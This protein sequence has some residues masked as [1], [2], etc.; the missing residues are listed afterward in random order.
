MPVV[1][2]LHCGDQAILQYLDRFGG[3]RLFWRVRRATFGFLHPGHIY[4]GGFVPGHWARPGDGDLSRT[5]P[6]GVFRS[7]GMET[8]SSNHRNPRRQGTGDQ[9]QHHRNQ[10]NPVAGG[11]RRRNTENC[12]LHGS[13]RQT[14][15]GRTTDGQAG[16]A[17]R[18]RR[19]GSQDRRSGNRAGYRRRTQNSR[20]GAAT[21]V[22]RRQQQDNHQIILRP[23]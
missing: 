10:D 1:A 8:G 5:S 17:R 12:R 15:P 2:G 3:Q 21:R 22:H 14:T 7:R 19:P 18:G 11:R 6:V 23:P 13:R 20:Q 4:L 9:H 16:P